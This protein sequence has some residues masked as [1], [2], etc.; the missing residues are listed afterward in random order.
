M[1]GEEIDDE[2]ED[3]GEPEDGG[4]D[5]FHQAVV[6]GTV[7]FEIPDANMTLTGRI[8]IIQLALDDRDSYER[9]FEVT[10]RME[11]MLFER[12]RFAML[13]SD[14]DVSQGTLTFRNGKIIVTTKTLA[15]ILVAYHFVVG[16]EDLRKGLELIL[17]DTRS[18]V[19]SVSG[20]TGA[21]KVVVTPSD[22]DSLVN[23]VARELPENGPI[24]RVRPKGR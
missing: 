3:E 19:C 17:D 20:A 5:V 9:I 2:P 4:S 14:G 6:L 12:F 11:I 21:Q 16:Y 10:R 7:Q 24:P 15:L 22:I 13:I 18:A 1:M 23:A 8:P